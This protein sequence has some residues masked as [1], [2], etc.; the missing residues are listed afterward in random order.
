MHK[1]PT[2]LASLA[3]GPFFSLVRVMKSC[4]CSSRGAGLAANFLFLFTDA[5]VNFLAG[6]EI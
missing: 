3:A 1:A 4:S 2:V 6:L 5:W